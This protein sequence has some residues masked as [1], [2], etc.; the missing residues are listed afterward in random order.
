MAF[1][2]SG[3]FVS[4]S[5]GLQQQQTQH[6]SKHNTGNSA[7]TTKTSSTTIFDNPSNTSTIIIITTYGV[8]VWYAANAT[9]PYTNDANPTVSARLCKL[10]RHGYD[11]II[12]SLMF[13]VRTRVYICFKLSVKPYDVMRVRFCWLYIVVLTQEGRSAWDEGMGYYVEWPITVERVRS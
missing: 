3:N 9:I 13:D 12:T 5:C 6:N 2:G 7:I 8:L 1:Y 10:L 4:S 11:L